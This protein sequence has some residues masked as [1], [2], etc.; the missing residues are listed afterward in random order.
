MLAGIRY[1]S[2]SVIRSDDA[3][4]QRGLNETL[5]LNCQAA[6]LPQNR[7]QVIESLNLKLW[8][9][10]EDGSVVGYCLRR[11]DALLP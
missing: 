9:A 10:A 1:R 7:K 3:D 8:K 11:R 4:V 6:Y 2:H 5:N